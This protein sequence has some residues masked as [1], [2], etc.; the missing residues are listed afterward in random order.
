MITRRA[1]RKSV[2]RLHLTDVA[3][4]PLSP[5]LSYVRNTLTAIG[6]ML[7]KKSV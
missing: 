4:P 2:N 5:V 6:V 7:W 3:S 1:A